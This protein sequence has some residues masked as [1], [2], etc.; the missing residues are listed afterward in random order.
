MGEISSRDRVIS[1][2][3][4]LQRPSF[5]TSSTSTTTVSTCSSCKF[6]AFQ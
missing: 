4:G 6:T 1:L 2:S 5:I 3:L